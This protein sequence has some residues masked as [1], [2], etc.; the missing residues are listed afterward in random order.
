MAENIIRAYAK[1]NSSFESVILRHVPDLAQRFWGVGGFRRTPGRF[2][3]SVTPPPWSP[4]V[5]QRVWLGPQG[6][7]R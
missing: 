5:L 2:T 6:P 4:Q 3:D 1:S 7:A